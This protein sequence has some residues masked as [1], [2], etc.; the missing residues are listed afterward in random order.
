MSL[1]LSISH[2][3]NADESRIFLSTSRQHIII[4]EQPNPERGAHEHRGL[5]DKKF[6]RHGAAPNICRLTVPEIGSLFSLN[7][8]NRL[9]SH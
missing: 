7:N 1:L 9:G 4:T 2:G 5:G 3:S 8:K 6:S